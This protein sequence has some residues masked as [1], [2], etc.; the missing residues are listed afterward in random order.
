MDSGRLATDGLSVQIDAEVQIGALRYC[1]GATID[2]AVL[3]ALGGAGLPAPG[4]VLSGIAGG[5]ATDDTLLAWRSPT[6]T[7]VLCP[8]G[9][10]TLAAVAAAIE[11]ALDACLVDQTGGIWVL[12]LQGPRVADLL[13]R[14]GSTTA[15]PPVGACRFGRLAE[16]TVGTL[17]VREGEV[18]LLVERLYAD[19][20]LAWIRETIADF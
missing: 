7:L 12:R 14:L 3:R 20:V 4:Q 19:H 6:E 5:T 18:L 17:S 10:D 11:G 13:R 15:V 1:D 8:R 16:I 2:D 9:N